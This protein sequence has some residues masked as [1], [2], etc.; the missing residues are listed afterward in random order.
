[1]RRLAHAA[2]AMVCKISAVASGADPAWTVDSIRRWVLGC[3]DSFGP[4]RCMFASNWPIDK[5]FGNYPKL[6]AAYE[7][8]VRDA[9]FADKDIDSLFAATAERVYRI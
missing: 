2:P 5:L 6:Y 9:G 8:I 7:Q 3:I 1:M 4:Q